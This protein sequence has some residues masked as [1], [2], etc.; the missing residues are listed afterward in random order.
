ME[1]RGKNH[2]VNEMKNK[3]QDLWQSFH[4]Q[5]WIL[6]RIGLSLIS[7]TKNEEET[8]TFSFFTLNWTM[9]NFFNILIC[10][11]LVRSFV[12]IHIQCPFFRALEYMYT[13]SCLLWFSHNKSRAEPW[14]RWIMYT[15]TR[16][17]KNENVCI[18]RFNSKC[19]DSFQLQSIFCVNPF[20]YTLMGIVSLF[21]G[22]PG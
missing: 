13:L 22:W 6:I 1:W 19:C 11:N 5:C 15:H 17:K 7:I 3:V 14:W 21:C 18:Y 20:H 10:E 4:S 9:T 12:I 16:R 2:S 8:Q